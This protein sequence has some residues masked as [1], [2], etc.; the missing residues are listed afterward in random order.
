MWDPDFPNIEHQKVRFSGFAI[1]RNEVNPGLGFSGFGKK[2]RGFRLKKYEILRWTLVRGSLG[3]VKNPKTKWSP[4]GTVTTLATQ[5]THYVSMW[6]QWFRLISLQILSLTITWIINI[7]IN[8]VV[9]KG[10]RSH[11]PYHLLRTFFIFAAS[12]MKVK[13]ECSQKMDE[14]VKISK[15]I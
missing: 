3:S 11:L 5:R 7:S 13:I 15:V 12:L 10:K 8:F 1:R 9:I 2:F 6:C 4:C 14:G